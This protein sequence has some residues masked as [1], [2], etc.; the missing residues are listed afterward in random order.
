[1][2]CYNFFDNFFFG[3]LERIM[4]K[5]T[6][7][8]TRRAASIL[9]NRYGFIRVRIAISKNGKAES[10]EANSERM[11]QRRSSAVACLVN[12]TLIQSEETVNETG[13]TW[14]SLFLT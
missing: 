1:M 3:Y 12:T 14:R 10:Q 4:L 6:K 13:I 8:T 9:K 7:P 11:I 5:R 2:L